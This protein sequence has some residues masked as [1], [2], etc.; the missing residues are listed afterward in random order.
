MRL[1]SR[2]QEAFASLGV[3][4]E[5]KTDNGPTYIGKVLDKFLKRWGVH[6]TFGI[7]HSP[8]GQAII[9]RTH[10][11]LK[12]LLDR[13]KR[14]ET[15]AT[16]YMRLN[17]ALY[18]LNFLNCSFAE[19]TPPIIRHFSNST[20]AKLKENPLVLVRNPET[21]QIEGPFKLITWG[22]G[23]ACVSTAVGPKWLAAKHVKPYRVQTQAETDPKTG[24]R[25]VGTQT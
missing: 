17:K 7:P 12:S 19:P 10:Q 16:P 1:L 18:V 3:P 11:T 2:G 22:K 4:Q 13:Q 8:K 15:D 20:R 25:E 21:G 23:Y 5:I 24:G 9:E 14:G 6:H